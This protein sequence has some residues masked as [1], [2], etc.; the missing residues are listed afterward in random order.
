M[1]LPSSF[2]PIYFYCKMKKK[3]TQ[4]KLHGLKLAR[5][6]SSSFI[7]LFIFVLQVCG[8]IQSNWNTKEYQKIKEVMKKQKCVFHTLNNAKNH[9]NSA[10][11]FKKMKT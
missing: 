11:N 4:K 2:D 7:Y 1:S 3:N 8:E 6:N 10:L 5:S 9:V